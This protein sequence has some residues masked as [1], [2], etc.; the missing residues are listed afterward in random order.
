MN[1]LA[2]IA[3]TRRTAGW[4]RNLEALA[5]LKTVGDEVDALAATDRCGGQLR[6]TA[7]ST[8]GSSGA[9]SGYDAAG[10]AGTRGSVKTLAISEPLVANASRR[11]SRRR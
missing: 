2:R 6:G 10:D 8:S 4:F 3:L 11:F 1:F 9:N 7:R 5:T